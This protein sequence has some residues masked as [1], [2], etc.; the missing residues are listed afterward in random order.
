VLLSFKRAPNDK[1]VYHNVFDFSYLREFPNHLSYQIGVNRTINEPAGALW[2]NKTN[3]LEPNFNVKENINTE[4]NLT[5]RYAPGEKFYQGKNYRRP[6]ITPYPILTLKLRMGLKNVINS[7]NEYQ[8][9]YLGLQ[10][11]IYWSFLGESDI[12][13]EGGRLFGKVPYTQLLI[14]RANQSYAYQYN[15]YNLMNFLEFVGDKFAAFTIDHHFNGFFFN[16]IPLFRRL[17]WREVF[18]FKAYYGGLDP[19]N[20][21]NLNPD[22]YIFP[23][24]AEGNPFTKTLEQKPYIEASVGVSNILKFFRVDVVKRLSYNDNEKVSPIGIRSTFKFDF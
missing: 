10:K 20:N 5:L 21:P 15:S 1:F 3:Y 7:E 2:Y 11:R 17:G 8:S 4:A 19:E 18:S 24:N 6:I 16:K 12:L 13:L 14:P 23:K 22:L 9:I